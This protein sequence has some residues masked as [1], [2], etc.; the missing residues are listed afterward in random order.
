MLY[1]FIPHSALTTIALDYTK[2]FF[3]LGVMLCGLVSLSGAMIALAA[4]RHHKSRTGK[5]ETAAAPLWQSYDT[6]A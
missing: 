4:L 2:E 6:A 5:P 1:G 3:P